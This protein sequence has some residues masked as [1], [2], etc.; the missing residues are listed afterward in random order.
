MVTRDVFNIMQTKTLHYISIGLVVFAVFM[1]L[2]LYG[3]QHSAGMHIAH[4]QVRLSVNAWAR[5]GWLEV[6]LCTCAIGGSNYAPKVNGPTLRIARR[7][8]GFLC[9]GQNTFLPRVLGNA[10][11]ISLLLS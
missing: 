1:G 5:F 8:G 2:H 10:L 9:G 7:Y 11:F 6:P 3:L 4:C